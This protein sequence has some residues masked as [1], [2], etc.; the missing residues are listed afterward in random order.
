M[1]MARFYLR[2]QGMQGETPT[3]EPLDAADIE[4]ART[5]VEMRLLLSNDFKEIRL[6]QRDHEVGVFRPSA[7]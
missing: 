6:Y 4:E 2:V 5:L 1:A 7:E 3:T